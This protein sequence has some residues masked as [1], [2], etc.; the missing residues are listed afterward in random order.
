M[1]TIFFLRLDICFLVWRLL[2][3]HLVAYSH[4]CLQNHIIDSFKHKIF[5][6]DIFFSP[7]CFVCIPS[8]YG[9]LHCSDHFDWRISVLS[10]TGVFL[11]TMGNKNIVKVFFGKESLCMQG[12]RLKQMLSII[13]HQDVSGLTQ[14]NTHL[15]LA[16]YLF[17]VS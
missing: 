17:F 6:I 12:P 5:I 7:K 10:L 14:F 11:S 3:S 15:I 9:C 4:L 2:Y 8:V 16:I 1:S 13:Q